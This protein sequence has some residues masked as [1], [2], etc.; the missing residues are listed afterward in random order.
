[1][2]SNPIKAW[3]ERDRCKTE[4][5]MKKKKKKKTQSKKHT[6]QCGWHLWKRSFKSD[7]SHAAFVLIVV[8]YEVVVVIFRK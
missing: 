5:D 2:V 4:R 6:K 1:M 8:D 3:A 7:S